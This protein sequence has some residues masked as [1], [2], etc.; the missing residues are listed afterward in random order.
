VEGPENKAIYSG[1]QANSEYQAKG[2]PVAQPSN[3]IPTKAPAKEGFSAQMAAGEALHKTYCM[4][5]HQAEGQ[6]MP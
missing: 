5:C 4:G 3:V 2:M 6:G 1:N